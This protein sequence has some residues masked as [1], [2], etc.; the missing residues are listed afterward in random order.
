MS[1]MLSRSLVLM[2][3]LGAALAVPYVVY[4]RTRRRP[5]VTFAT[6]L[7]IAAAIYVAFALFAADW[8]S[9]LV[10]LGGVLLFAA[11]A[12]GGLRWRSHLLA[13]G[14]LAH[15]GWD[16]LLHPVQLGGQIDGHAPW[17]YPALCIGF[18]LVVAGSIRGSR[19]VA[20]R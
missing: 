18:D 13:I 5:A 6:G 7:M 4:A 9:V 10:E 14:W 11:I 2:I 17:W 16:L 12:F 8:H 1:T 15:V 3:V 20:G 19:A